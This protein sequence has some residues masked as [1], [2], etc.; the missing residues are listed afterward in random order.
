MCANGLTGM[1]QRRLFN[2]RYRPQSTSNCRTRRIPTSRAALAAQPVSTGIK[3]RFIK[4]CCLVGLSQHH[5]I[6][7][8][9]GSY[10]FD[11]CKRQTFAD[12]IS[13]GPRCH[14]THAIVTGKHRLAAC[15]IGARGIRCIAIEFQQ[16]Q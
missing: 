11:K 6:H 5:H 10:A 13:I 7:H 2:A 15:R 8:V 16:H 3:G 4:Y 9:S 1:R 12:T 14:T